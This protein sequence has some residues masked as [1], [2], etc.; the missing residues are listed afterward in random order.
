MDK[1][2]I[3]ILLAIVAGAYLLTRR[4]AAQTVSQP[5]F[6]S[7]GVQPATAA[8]INVGG[9]FGAIGSLFSGSSSSASPAA[10]GTS[11]TDPISG[12]NPVWSNQD[13]MAVNPPNMYGDVPGYF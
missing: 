5:M 13:L 2:K 6:Y 8:P 1:E 9:L 3:L 4:T 10:P 11:W 7:P 12:V